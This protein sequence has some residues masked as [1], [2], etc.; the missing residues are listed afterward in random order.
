M[1]E[2]GSRTN[3]NIVSR[4]QR[5]LP[6]AC[7][8]F[9]SFLSWRAT[10]AQ[11]WMSGRRPRRQRNTGPEQGKMWT[12]HVQSET[13]IRFHVAILPRWK[14]WDRRQ[15]IRSGRAGRKQFVNTSVRTWDSFGSPLLLERR[16]CPVAISPCALR[17]RN[18]RHRGGRLCRLTVRQSAAEAQPKRELISRTCEENVQGGESRARERRVVFGDR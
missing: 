13:Y 16:G 8:P 3:R 14:E 1:T 5:K 11:W 12:Q 10:L 15:V 2:H 18:I 17:V 9:P 6:S 4:Y 7:R